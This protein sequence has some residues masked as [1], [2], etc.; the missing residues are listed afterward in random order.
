LL[1]ELLPDRVRVL[2]PAHPETLIT[3]NNLAYWV[4]VGGDV[5]GALR[6]LEELLPD[7]VR[8]LGP[9]HPDTLAT[10]NYIAHR[11]EVLHPDMD[12]PGD[13]MNL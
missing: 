13:A 11:A 10:R 1:E 12:N 4:G 6:L 3:R 7:L 8:V 5:A 2:C 9:A